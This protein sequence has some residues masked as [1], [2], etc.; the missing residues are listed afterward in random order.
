MTVI[1]NDPVSHPPLGLPRVDTGAGV[2][3]MS[4]LS[5]GVG[6]GV[7]SPLSVGVVGVG[8]TSPLVVGVGGVGVTSPLSVG[9]GVM[10]SLSVGSGVTEAPEYTALIT[11]RPETPRFSNGVISS[12]CSLS[13]SVSVLKISWSVL[14]MSVDLFSA[15]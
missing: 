3:V 9:V 11:S 6:V 7:M 15:V 10:S 5:D 8:V 1:E 12:L 13:G 14:M 4:S 2:G